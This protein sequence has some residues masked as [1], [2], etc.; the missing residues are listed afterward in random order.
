M[1]SLI[2]VVQVAV[3][4]TAVSSVLSALTAIVAGRIASDTWTKNGD[5][6]SLTTAELLTKLGVTDP[7]AADTTPFY[8][9][10]WYF[11]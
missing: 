7:K 8:E 5:T 10:Q 4:F 9:A 6:K 1:P 2:S 3:A 11:L